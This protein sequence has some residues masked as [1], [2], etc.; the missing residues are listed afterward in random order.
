MSKAV[1]ELILMTSGQASPYI[2]IERT[3]ESLIYKCDLGMPIWACQNMPIYSMGIPRYALIL[4]LMTLGQGSPYMD[5]KW[6]RM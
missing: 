2:G 5:I 4:L 3:R 6:T 1:K